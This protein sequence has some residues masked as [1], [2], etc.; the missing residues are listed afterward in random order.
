LQKNGKPLVHIGHFPADV[1]EEVVGNDQEE[2]PPETQQGATQHTN[3]DKQ[4]THKRPT[5]QPEHDT[6]PQQDPRKDVSAN[7]KGIVASVSEVTNPKI[8][9][10]ADNWVS[11]EA[12]MLLSSDIT[13]INE[14]ANRLHQRYGMEVAV[15][16]LTD[17]TGYEDGDIHGFFTELF[18]FWGVGDP[19]ANNGLVIGLVKTKRRLEMV[20]GTGLESFFTDREVRVRV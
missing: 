14:V 20:T 11:D 7:F 17:T 2:A 8:C 15:V 16:T 9:G 19:N 6:R 3:K 13:T 10:A 1:V 5:Q 4:P 18:N 12:S